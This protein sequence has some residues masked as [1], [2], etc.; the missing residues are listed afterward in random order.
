[1]HRFRLLPLGEIVYA[2]WLSLS[3]ECQTNHSL[4]KLNQSVEFYNTILRFQ[5]DTND[6]RNKSRTYFSRDQPMCKNIKLSQPPVVSLVKQTEYSL[7]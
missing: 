5:A 2:V 7:S 6:I 4:T 1:M 3:V